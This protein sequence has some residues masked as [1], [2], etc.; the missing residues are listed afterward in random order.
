MKKVLLTGASGFLGSHLLRYFLSIG[1]SVIILKRSTSKTWRIDDLLDQVAR[2]DI[3]LIPVERAFIEHKIDIVIHTACTYG[4]NNESLDEIVNTNITY[5]LNVLDSCL[6]HGTKY[7]VNTDTLLQRLN[8]Y[9]LSK[10]QFTE[11]LKLAAVNLKVVNIKIEH[12][13]GVNDDSNKLLPW[14]LSRLQQNT[15]EIALTEGTQKRDFIF[16]DDVVSAY[17][18]IV[19]NIENFNNFY[20]FQVGTGHLISVKDFLLK[21]KEI[22]ESYNGKILT[23]LNFGA[24]PFQKDEELSVNIDI[25]NLKNLGWEA[26]VDIETGLNAVIKKSQVG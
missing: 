22:F 23:K 3:D 15:D 4:R 9:S 19:K 1:Y 25:T 5:G 6:K 13:F 26:S 16:I 14:F 18:L 24:I 17:G 10:K 21:S 8:P 2:Y 7:F 20:E 12:M 11:W